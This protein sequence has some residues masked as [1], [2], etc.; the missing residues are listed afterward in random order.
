MVPNQT[1]KNL[2]SLTNRRRAFFVHKHILLLFPSPECRDSFLTP[3]GSN[4]GAKRETGKTLPFPNSA[5]AK[6][7][8]IFFDERLHV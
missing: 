6:E 7:N 3:K 5:E 2:Q 8:K 4:L 1:S